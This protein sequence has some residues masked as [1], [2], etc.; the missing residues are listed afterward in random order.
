MNNE[1]VKEWYNNFSN[2]QSTIGVNVRHYTIMNYL[3][4]AGLKKDHNILEIGCGIGTLTSLI[5]KY[6]KGEIVATD[7]SDKS[8][9]LARENL[10]K[11]KN[12][13]FVVTDMNSFEYPEMFDFVVLPDVLEHIPSQDHA[14]L[15]E[16]ISKLMHDESIIVIHIPHPTALDYIRQHTPEKLQIIDQ[17]L[18]ADMIMETVYA[19]DLILV[20]YEA[21]SLTNEQPDYVLIKL[22]KKLPYKIFDPLKK[23]RIIYKKMLARIKF[24][25][26]RF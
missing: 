8:I 13:D 18:Q 12:I 20:H 14:Q 4:D 1:A 22:K 15:F 24:A 16:C 23:K 17:S 25:I 6:V 7:I 11:R 10:G 9:Q 5:A 19:K 26:A 21:Y 3:I 2:K